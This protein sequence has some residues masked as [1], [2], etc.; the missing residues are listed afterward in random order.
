M[1]AR[2]PSNLGARIQLPEIKSAIA[3]RDS[4][5]NILVLMPE[6]GHVL[7]NGRLSFGRVL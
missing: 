2:T 6:G 5:E 1:R 3:S 7:A 4:S